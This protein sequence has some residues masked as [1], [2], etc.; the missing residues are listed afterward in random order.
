MVS[1]NLDRLGHVRR[2]V[3]EQVLLDNGEGMPT[4]TIKISGVLPNQALIGRV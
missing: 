4:S 3:P 2:G 1:E